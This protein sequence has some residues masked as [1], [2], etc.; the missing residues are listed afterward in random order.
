MKINKIIILI[1]T[2]LI[3]IP[4]IAIANDTLVYIDKNNID[5][6]YHRLTCSFIEPN[7]YTSISVEDA[8][9]KGYRSCS[10][11]N[12]PVSDTEKKLKDE[13]YQERLEKAKQLANEHIAS[14]SSTSTSDTRTVYITK[15]DSKYHAYGCDA[16]K[17]TPSKTTV[18]TAKNRGYAPCKICDP[19]GLATELY[20]LNNNNK[21]S[22]LNSFDIEYLIALAISGILFMLFPI[23]IKVKK[24][25]FN[26]KSQ[27][28]LFVIFNSVIIGFG[29]L[30]FIFFNDIYY[31]NYILFPFIYG[32]INYIL[33]KNNIDDTIPTTEIK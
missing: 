6:K 33:L 17:N 5:T 15:T 8:F 13:E 32:I 10:I 14:S 7:R 21:F 9:N 29:Y 27:V 16:L 30:L 18:E 19:Y 2:N 12:P 24:F 23:I 4:S 31:W 3:F 1:I 22:F 26:D 28:R 25:M 20:G 11:C